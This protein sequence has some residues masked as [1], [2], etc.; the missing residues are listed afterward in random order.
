[1]A[2]LGRLGRSQNASPG[3]LSPAGRGETSWIR[4]GTLASWQMRREPAAGSDGFDIPGQSA[5]I[6]GLK[7]NAA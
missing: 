3:S 5:L 1:M 4:V 6:V 2:V 7:K